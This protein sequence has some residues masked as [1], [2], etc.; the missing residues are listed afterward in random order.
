MIKSI[1]VYVGLLCGFSAAQL[2]ALS[3]LGACEGEFSAAFYLASLRKKN[4]GHG[5]ERR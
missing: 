4:N 3:L 5:G 1:G 2:A